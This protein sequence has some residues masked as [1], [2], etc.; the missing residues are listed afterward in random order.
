MQA[1]KEDK[2]KTKL[3]M[4]TAAENLVE[5]INQNAKEMNKK[6]DKNKVNVVK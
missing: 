1:I 6:L 2:A 3:I 5:K 4:K